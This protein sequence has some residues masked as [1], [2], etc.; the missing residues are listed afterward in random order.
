[1]L[2]RACFPIGGIRAYIALLFH[3]QGLLLTESAED[4]A[5]AAE[6]REASADVG[7]GFRWSMVV[8]RE[9]LE[10]LEDLAG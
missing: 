6:P 7:E 8:I 4:R 9:R 10:S 5:G 1:M 3:I 2:L